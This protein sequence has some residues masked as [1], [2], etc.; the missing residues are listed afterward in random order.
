MDPIQPNSLSSSF[1]QSNALEPIGDIERLRDILYG[2]R[3]RSLEGRLDEVDQRI[4]RLFNELN[5]RIDHEV[6]ELIQRVDAAAKRLD[7]RILTLR[8]QSAAELRQA[9]DNLSRRLEQQATQQEQNLQQART[10]AH[11]ELEELRT[12]IQ[13]WR[14]KTGQ[15]LAALAAQWKDETGQG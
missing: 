8:A 5:R 9:V 12:E 14:Q 10:A 1:D 13:A 7:D 15:V 2:D 6:E 11:R 4:T 3:V